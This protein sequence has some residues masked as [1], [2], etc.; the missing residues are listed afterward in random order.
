VASVLAY[1]QAKMGGY[2][3]AQRFYIK[4]SYI[5]DGK[6]VYIQLLPK[7]AVKWFSLT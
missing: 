6:G 4:R 3:A 7:K 2:G 1:M 5:S